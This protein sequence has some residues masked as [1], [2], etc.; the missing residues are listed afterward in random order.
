[1]NQKQIGIIAVLIA[2]VMWAIEP[3]FAKL[4]YV[5][6]DFIQTSAIKAFVVTITALT[7]VLISKDKALQ[8][9]KK[10]IPIYLYITLIGVLFADLIYYFAL[11][12]IPILNAVLIAHMQPMFIIIFGYLILKSDKLGKLDYIAVFLMM[13]SAIF[14]TTKTFENA[15]NLRFGSM[16]DAMVLLATIAWATTAIAMRKYLTGE[17]AGKI[18]FYRY[19][20]ASIFFAGYLVII[21]SFHVNQ[22]QIIVGIIVGIGTICY[23]EGLKR[24]KA[25]NVSALELAAPVFAALIGFFYLGEVVTIMQIMGIL[26]LFIGVY[27]ISNKEK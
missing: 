9:S 25:A 19:F 18:T 26:L 15:L 22:Y 12:Q 5:E 8:I 11:T 21:N 24:L 1:M 16:G 23:Y 3:V 4:S 10:K 27:F 14:V 7:Y 17:N 2:A 6:S 13:L 20:I